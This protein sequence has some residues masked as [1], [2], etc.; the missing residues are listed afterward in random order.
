MCARRT[1]SHK[2]CIPSG[3]WSRERECH[4]RIALRDIPGANTCSKKH[5]PEGGGG[6]RRAPV[7]FA[8]RAVELACART[9]ARAAN[10]VNKP[11]PHL[12]AV[13]PR[14]FGHHR[15]PRRQA[16]GFRDSLWVAEGFAD[17]A[18]A[19]AERPAQLCSAPGFR[20]LAALAEVRPCEFD[21][22]HRVS[23]HGVRC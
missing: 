21:G 4:A 13:A 15:A 1:F 9:V 3:T 14:L 7:F 8:P 16:P 18:G 12:R 2:S 22:M 11:A 20:T 5:K 6:V 23:L 10:P 19:A 17:I